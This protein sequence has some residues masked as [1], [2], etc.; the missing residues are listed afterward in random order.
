MWHELFKAAPDQKLVKV[1]G[2]TER[3]FCPQI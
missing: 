3:G 2:L 1:T